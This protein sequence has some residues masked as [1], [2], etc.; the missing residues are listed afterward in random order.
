MLAIQSYSKLQVGGVQ[1]P[2][3]ETLGCL[4]APPATGWRSLVRMLKVWKIQVRSRAMQ[5]H[6]GP[7]SLGG[8]H[9]LPAVQAEHPKAY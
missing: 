8:L 2:Q 4:H 5:M 3:G 9:A 1:A 6:L 7:E